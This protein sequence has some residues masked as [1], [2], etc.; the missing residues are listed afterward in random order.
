MLFPQWYRADLT[1]I[2]LHEKEA[3]KER[4][5]MTSIASSPPLS[6]FTD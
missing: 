4:A 2:V 1:L 5:S 6:G 3:E